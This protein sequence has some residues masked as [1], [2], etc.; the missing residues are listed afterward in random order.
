MALTTTQQQFL[1][2]F[3]KTLSVQE[4]Q[5]IA[6][7]D[8]VPA[9]YF[10]A[11]EYNANECARLVNIGKKTASCGLKESWDYDNEP[12]PKVGALTIVTNWDEEPVCIIQ[13]T[14][15][16]FARFNEVTREFAE[17]EGEGDGTYEWWREA[18]IDF[19]TKYA[20]SIDSQFCEQSELI[21]ERF[22]KVY[23]T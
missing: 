3:L 9:E 6:N 19:F 11:D 12:Y 18:H 22:K 16:S 15:V 23:P 21:L 2:D 8:N 1:N 20:Q 17:A 5:S 10:C 13:L 4:I 14:E 7:I